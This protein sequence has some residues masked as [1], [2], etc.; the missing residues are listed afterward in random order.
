MKKK[1]FDTRK[2]DD[3]AAQAK[4]AWG[5][6]EA[7]R[8]YE[9]RDQRTTQEERKV[10]EEGLMDLMRRFGEIR[11]LSP[12]SAEAQALVQE[13]RDFITASF[14]TCTVPI[15][16]G[17][18]RM[19]DGGGAITENIDEAGGPGT[20]AFAARAMEAYAMRTKE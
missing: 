2:M 19:Y 13:L 9:E 17:L 16:R 20:A 3:Y 11:H 5:K 15:L 18:G 1:S 7:W 8:E 4:A 10:Q 12:E 14:Y 6:T